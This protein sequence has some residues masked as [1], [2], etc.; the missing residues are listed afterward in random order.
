MKG[1]PTPPYS[2]SFSP[3]LPLIYPFPL[4]PPPSLS[5]PSFSHSLSITFSPAFSLINLFSRSKVMVVKRGR[6]GEGGEREVEQGGAGGGRRR[7]QRC[8]YEGSVPHTI[9][10][11]LAFVYKRSALQLL[12]GSSAQRDKAT[13]ILHSPHLL[14]LSSPTSSLLYPFLC[15]L[16]L[17]PPF[18]LSV[19]H[20]LLST[21]YFILYMTNLAMIVR[22]VS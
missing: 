8:V 10:S 20:V 17:P 5:F 4:F 18:F 1:A 3:F 21:Y 6:R 14:L 2:A 7:G 13:V 12:V 15:I 19:S 11:P 16:S 22:S 9:Y